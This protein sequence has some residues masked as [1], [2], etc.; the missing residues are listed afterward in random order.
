MDANISVRR[1]NEPLGIRTEVKNLNSI[2]LVKQ[3]MSH[4]NRVL[5]FAKRLFTIQHDK[6]LMSKKYL[7]CTIISMN[8]L[9]NSTTILYIFTK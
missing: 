6:A 8:K 5:Y 7:G 3:N 2:R 4:L 9:I 1:P